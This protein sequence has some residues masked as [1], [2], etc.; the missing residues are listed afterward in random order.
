[1]NCPCEIRYNL[2][3]VV[4]SLCA[5]SVRRDRCSLGKARLE[6]VTIATESLSWVIVET[7]IVVFLTICRCFLGWMLGCAERRGPVESVSQSR[8]NDR[9]SASKSD[10]VAV[11]CRCI[12]AAPVAHPIMLCTICLSPTLLCTYIHF[13]DTAF[14]FQALQ[15]YRIYCWILGAKVLISTILPK[16]IAN[17]INCD[18]TR[19]I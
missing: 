15:Y 9:C 12:C 18:W 2:R 10:C 6:P 19:S 16:A 3:Y 14:G 7:K 17:C 13:Q 8:S 11:V 1:M 4:S 5:S